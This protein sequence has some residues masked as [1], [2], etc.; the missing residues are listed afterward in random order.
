MRRTFGA[1]FSRLMWG[2]LLYALVGLP[3]AIFCFVWLV[4]FLSL[5]FGLAITLIGLPII[6]LTIYS[7]RGFGAAYRG[8]GRSLLGVTVETPRTD[9]AWSG[10]LRALS[11]RTGWRATLFVFVQFPLALLYFTVAVTLWAIDLGGLSYWIWRQ[12]LPVQHDRGVGHRGGQ[13]VPHYFLDTTPRIVGTAVV[14]FVILLLTPAITHGLLA[15]DRALIRG[16]LGPTAASKRI[17][18]LEDTRAMAVDDSA[19]SLRRIERDLHDG[20]QAR[21]V[22]LAMSLGLAKEELAR[23]GSADDDPDIALARVRELVETAHSEAKGTIVDLR[24]LAR[25]IHPPAL[26]NGLADALATLAARCP[27]ATALHVELAN[28]PSAAVESIVYFCT[29]ELLTNIVKHS[30]A[31]HASIDVREVGNGLFVRVGDDGAGGAASGRAGGSGLSGLAGRVATVD[32]TLDVSSP[33][34]GPTLITIGIPL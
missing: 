1:F 30:G 34:G 28:R 13:L 17:K 29:A 26:D 21:L 14:G 12:Y 32:G 5:G 27:V 20:A 11:D 19:A 31:H 3:L 4:G 18:A 25:G 2:E 22:A 16:L 6:G 33:E 9:L 15:L 23:N 24:D 10:R 7:A 8:L